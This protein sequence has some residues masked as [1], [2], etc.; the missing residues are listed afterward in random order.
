M[1]ADNSETLADDDGDF[2]DWL[3]LHNAGAVD[4]DASGWLLTDD[5]ELGD[6]WA[7]PQG[8]IIGADQYALVWASGAPPR[9]SCVHA[10]RE[11]NRV[12]NA[13]HRAGTDISP[14]FEAARR[15]SKQPARRRQRPRRPRRRRHARGRTAREL[16]AERIW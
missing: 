3:E 7:L 11:A 15:L 6:V 2:S 9:C 16:Q 13:R 10:R 5:P 12:R 4:V 14:I 8:T 1:M